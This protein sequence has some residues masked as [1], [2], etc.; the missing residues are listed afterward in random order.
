MKKNIYEYIWLDKINNFRSKTKVYET[1][2]NNLNTLIKPTLDS[3]VPLWNYDGSSTNQ[4]NVS[5]V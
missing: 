1:K 3:V 2:D 5:K 4:A